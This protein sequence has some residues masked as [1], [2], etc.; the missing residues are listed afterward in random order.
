MQHDN[1]SGITARSYLKLVIINLHFQAQ[2]LSW[3]INANLRMNVDRKWTYMCKIHGHSGLVD[4][5]GGNIFSCSGWFILHKQT[6][7]QGFDVI[8]YCSMVL[9]CRRAWVSWVNI[10]CIDNPAFI[11]WYT[12]YQFHIYFHPYFPNMHCILDCYQLFN[13]CVVYKWNL[14]MD[15]IDFDYLPKSSSQATLWYI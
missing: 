2:L 9:S 10:C 14:P 12:L 1:E 5:N 11:G 4:M 15:G 7:P 8:E 13:F 6:I 3:N